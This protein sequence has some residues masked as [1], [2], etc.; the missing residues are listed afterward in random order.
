M[1]PLYSQD[2]EPRAHTLLVTGR[3]EPWLWYGWVQRHCWVGPGQY[4]PY[5]LSCLDCHADAVAGVAHWFENVGLWEATGACT[6]RE[7]F[8]CLTMVVAF[9]TYIELRARAVIWGYKI[10]PFW[11]AR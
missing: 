1:F 4:M 11:G 2:I 7:L 6:V 8:E 3:D 9:T 5:C 10:D